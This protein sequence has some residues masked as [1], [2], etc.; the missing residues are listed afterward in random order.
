MNVIKANKTHK[1]HVLILLD[2]F[3]DVCYKICKIDPN[4][5]SESARK[6]GGELFDKY[7]ESCDFAIFLAMDGEKYIGVSTVYKIPLV[8]KGVYDA[9]IIEFYVEEEFQGTGTAQLLMDS[10]VNWARENNICT[11]EL[12]SDNELLRAHRF[13][14]KYG[15][16]NH[17]K[18]FKLIL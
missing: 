5:H 8:R 2:N 14:E 17:A 4:F 9:E 7:I 12:E 13:Y 3:R 16:K 11:I 6:L 10:V 18:G 15:F 1:E